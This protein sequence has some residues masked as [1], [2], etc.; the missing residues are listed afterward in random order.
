MATATSHLLLCGQPPKNS[1]EQLIV[2]GNGSR[3]Y[4]GSLTTQQV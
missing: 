1:D 4:M 3:I 2:I